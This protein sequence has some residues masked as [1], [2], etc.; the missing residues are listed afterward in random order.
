[1]ALVKF[2]ADD[3]ERQRPFI[4]PDQRQPR[5]RQIGDR[6]HHAADPQA[7]RQ[8][9]APRHEAAGEASNQ[10]RGKADALDDRGIVV[11]GEAEVDHEGRGHGAGKCIGEFVEHDK[12]K[13]RPG[14]VARQEFGERADCGMQHTCKAGLG[15]VAAS[16]RSDGSGSVANSAVAVPISTSAAI[17]T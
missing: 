3:G 4:D 7:R 12:G 5:E 6:L 17:A 13:R 9:I 1:M 10:G 15:R 8:R 11:A 14:I 2:S 16:A